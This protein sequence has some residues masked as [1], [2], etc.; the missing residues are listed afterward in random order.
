MGKWMVNTNLYSDIWRGE[1]FD[2]KEQAIKE[3]RKQA[4]EEGLNKFEIGETEPPLNVGIDVD[5]VIEDVQAIMYDDIG[6]VAEDYLDDVSKEHL[7]ELEEKLN[8][9]FFKWQKE[10][11]YE[12]NFYKIINIEEIYV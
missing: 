12:P 8:E 6:E 2:T 9:V 7:L 5:R 3:G 4:M 10:H 11:G 1:E